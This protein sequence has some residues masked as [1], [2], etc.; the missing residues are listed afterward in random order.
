MPHNL[1]HDKNIV[2]RLSGSIVITVIAFSFLIQCM[3]YSYAEDVVQD[4]YI[5]GIA[6]GNMDIPKVIIE[7]PS[8]GSLNAYRLHDS[9]KGYEIIEIQQKGILLKKGEIVVSV[10]L[11]NKSSL[12]HG[13]EE[14]QGYEEPQ[15]F[16]FQ[17]DQ[18]DIDNLSEHIHTELR[19]DIGRKDNS[20]SVGVTVTDIKEGNFMNIMGIE[21]GDVLLEFNDTQINNPE[22]LG[23]ALEKLINKELI[24]PEDGS[25]RI[26]FE[27][28]GVYQTRYGEMQ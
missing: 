8:S 13:G 2:C 6:V 21:P 25:I 15:Y 22:D 1:F 18:I 11:S 17:R 26:A 16:T 14:Y 24:N 9:V 19:P 23:N 28:D 7:D 10:L 4:I 5:R 12:V 27:R 20:L 3:H